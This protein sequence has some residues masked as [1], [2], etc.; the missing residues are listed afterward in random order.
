MKRLALAIA[1]VVALPTFA[2]ETFLQLPSD[3]TN[4]GKM[5]RM[6]S[7]VVGANTVYDQ[8][9][10]ISDG[11][12]GGPLGIAGSALFIDFATSAKAALADNTANPTV[13]SLGAYMMC[14]DG[15]TWDRCPGDSTNG[16][17]VNIKSSV[18]LGRSWSLSSGT[19]VV[20]I[21]QTDSG[22][23]TA[24]GALNAAISVAISGEAG[25]GFELTAGTLI[26]TL[27]PELS[28][29]GGTTWTGTQ[30]FDTATNST[31]PSIVYTASNTVAQRTIVAGNGVS[32]ARVRVS[33][34]TSGT[35]NATIRASTSDS[36]LQ[37]MTKIDGTKATYR[38]SA[39]GQV[40]AASAT[41]PCFAVYGSATKTV[42]VTLVRVTATIATAALEAVQII[43]F[44]TAPSAGT[45]TAF[46]AIPLDALDPAT[47]ATSLLKYTVAPT[48]G[49]AVGAVESFRCL[50]G[51]ATVT[52]NCQVEWNFGD[53][54]GARTIVLR[55]TA[56]GIG[57]IVTVGATVDA[58][59]EFTEE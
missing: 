6:R 10:F 49:T 17:F 23:T 16:L 20:T 50:A 43:K 44:S 32:N 5:L 27:V 26:G 37:Y 22:T 21:V 30:F 35:A 9:M 48:A 40:C 29:D 52:G 28:Y 47:T 51:S 33:A 42:R 7:N 36:Q 8:A 34:Y 12:G 57:I 15:A 2:A 1:F 56:Q 14:F 55:G 31:S 18:A 39:T 4:T 19:D 3:T 41:A 24:L 59:V 46:T 53:R 13:P 45:S 11:S 58:T 25:A 38:A 54:P